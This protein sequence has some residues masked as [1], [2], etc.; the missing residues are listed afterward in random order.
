VYLYLSDIADVCYKVSSYYD[1]AAERG[2]AWNDPD[3]AID[4][5]VA[6]PILSER[7]R[8]LPSLASIARELPDW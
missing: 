7:D 4:W 6:E 1:P 8:A 5:Q 2:I 3:L